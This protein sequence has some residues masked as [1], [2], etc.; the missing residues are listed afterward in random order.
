MDFEYHSQKTSN[1]LRTFYNNYLH[2]NTSL[3]DI[4]K[5]N[6]YNIVYALY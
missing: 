5:I 3:T 1:K 2:K 4:C 6:S